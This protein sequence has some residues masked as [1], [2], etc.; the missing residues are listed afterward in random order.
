MLNIFAITAPI[1]LSIG[2]GYAATRQGLFSKADG[3]AM[4]KFVLNFALPAMLFNALAQRDFSD[5]LHPSYF[6]AYGLGSLITFLVGYLGWRYAKR[7]SV[8]Q[9]GIAALGFCSSN[10]GY[11]GFPILLQVLG[12]VAGVALALTVIIEN[13]FIIPLGLAVAESGETQHLPWYHTVLQSLKRMA[14]APLMWAI[15]LGF[16][17]AMWQ[18]HLPEFLA[19][20]VNLFAAACSAIALFVNGGSLVGLRVL[21]LWRDIRWL[22]MGKL[23]LHPLMVG[24]MLWLVGPMETNLQISAI[25]LA[26]MPMMGIYPLLAQRYG[27]EGLC[28]S[29]L[30]VTTMVSFFTIS[31]ILW[32]LMQ[33]PGWL[34]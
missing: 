27:E 14:Q 34:A 5:V 10:S 19:K 25:L 9:S 21:G 8:A 17:C 13:M 33:V 30:L 2:L 15:V 29:A 11:V 7:K 16:L 24:L 12:P 20:T 28:A 31:L 32:G 4:G 22:V 26:S 1:Y 3:Q 6:L 18:I 23:L